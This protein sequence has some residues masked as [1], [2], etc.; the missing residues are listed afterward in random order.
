[1]ID[2]VKLWGIP[3][4]WAL[5]GAAV[6]LF[7]FGDVNEDARLFVAGATVLGV[8]AALLSAWSAARS[9][10]RLAGALLIGSAVVTPTYFAWPLNVVPL[11]AGVV[12]VRGNQRA[13]RALGR[14]QPTG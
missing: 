11:V 1:M 2:R 12:I 8:G 9:R 13:R 14:T 3:A 10:H 4:I 6:A 7:T 5:T